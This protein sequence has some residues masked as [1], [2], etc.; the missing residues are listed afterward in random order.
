[1]GWFL[2]TDEYIRDADFLT[3]L[4]VIFV[5]ISCLYGFFLMFVTIW[6]RVGNKPFLTISDKGI[7]VNGLLKKKTSTL[8]ML[9][10]LTLDRIITYILCLYSTILKLRR[11]NWRA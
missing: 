2:V 7:A 3:I 9:F 4:S 6:E 10:R 1:M 5:S 8:Q 11:K